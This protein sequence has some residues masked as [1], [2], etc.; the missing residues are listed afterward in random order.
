MYLQNLINIIT[1]NIQIKGHTHTHTE[2]DIQTR[3]HHDISL[4]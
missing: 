4:I 3:T 2:T 1:Y